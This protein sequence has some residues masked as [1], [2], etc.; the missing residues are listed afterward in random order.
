M[1]NAHVVVPLMTAINREM[2]ERA[3]DLRY[4]SWGRVTPVLISHI[5]PG[6]QTDPSVW[7]RRRGN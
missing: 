1:E 5:F 7:G 3:K 2:I 6:L 4:G